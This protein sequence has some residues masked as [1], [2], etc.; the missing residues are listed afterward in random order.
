MTLDIALPLVNINSCM[1]FVN[2]KCNFY[3]VTGV[4]KS[5]FDN[6]NIGLFIDI[7]FPYQTTEGKKTI[8]I[9]PMATIDYWCITD[10]GI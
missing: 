5:F 3:W 4:L 1:Y 2:A 8:L 10:N 9:N 7:Y 6:T